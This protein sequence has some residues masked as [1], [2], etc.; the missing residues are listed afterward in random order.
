MSFPIPGTFSYLWVI[1]IFFEHG[2]RLYTNFSNLVWSKFFTRFH[3]NHLNEPNSNSVKKTKTD[4]ALSS[5]PSVCSSAL[6]FQQTQTL[7]LSRNKW[8]KLYSDLTYTS[9][10]FF[11]FEF[12]IVTEFQR[13]YVP[14]MV[15]SLFSPPHWVGGGDG[16]WH[17][18]P[19]S[20]IPYAYYKK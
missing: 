11:L 14:V 15:S 3:V 4:T 17:T 16:V 13:F 10:F 19:T 8:I 18:M 7:D 12:S 2:Q 20:V 9:Q 6:R 1:E 5:L